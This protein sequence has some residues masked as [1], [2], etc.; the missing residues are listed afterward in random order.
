MPRAFLAARLWT[1]VATGMTGMTAPSIRC[2]AVDPLHVFV[3]G[4]VMDDMVKR[5]PGFSLP[6]SPT[7]ER[8]GEQIE[9][10]RRRDTVERRKKRRSTF[11]IQELARSSRRID[12]SG[13]GRGTNPARSLQRTGTPSVANEHRNWGVKASSYVA[14]V[15]P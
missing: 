10:E 14:C 13:L 4:T 3:L 9:R 5:R 7:L 11:K 15:V 2:D 8:D 1:G 12:T 6:R